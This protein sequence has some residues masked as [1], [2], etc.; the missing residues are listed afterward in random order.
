ME[1]QGRVASVY[2]M[3]AMGGLVVGSAIGGVIAQHAGLAAPFWFAFVGSAILLSL[4]WRR[5]PQ[6]AH[7]E[8]GELVRR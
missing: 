1:F 2:M 6:I 5:L 8:E 3:G 7:S 4:I